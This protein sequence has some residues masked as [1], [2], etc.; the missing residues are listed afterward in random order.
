MSKVK[1]EQALF[2]I[3]L[4]ASLT[5]TRQSFVQK[6]ANQYLDQTVVQH[7]INALLNEL[8]PLVKND[9]SVVRLTTF[10]GGKL[11]KKKNNL[12]VNKQIPPLVI[13][14]RLPNLKINTLFSESISFESEANTKIS[15]F[16]TKSVDEFEGVEFDPD[17]LML[18]G[19][20]TQVGDHQFDLYGST[21]L[22]NGQVQSVVVRIKVT[23]VPDPKSLWKNIPSDETARFHKPDTHHAYCENSSMLLMGCSVRGRSHAHKGI[24]RDDDFKLYCDKSSEWIIS[25]VADGAGS[26]KYSRQGA[27]VAVSNATDSLKESL[28]GH[29]GSALEK[30][31]NDFSNDSNEENQKSLLEVYQHTIVKAVFSAAKAINNCVDASKGD[32]VKDFSTTLILAA[33]KKVQGG[34]LVISFWI[35]DGGIAIYDKNKTVVLMGEPDSGEFAGQTRFLDNRIFEDGSVYRRV[36]VEKVESMSALILATDGITDAWFETEKQ[37]DSLPHWD[38]LWNELEPHIT[39]KNREDGL[40]GLTQWMDFWSKGNHDDRTISVCLV[41]E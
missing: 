19:T 27:F 23:F 2:E 39:N 6:R 13:N 7:H 25:C 28:N 32:S 24:H 26:C 15:F 17:K 33:H 34:Y 31:Y 30:T 4:Q 5:N 38:R 35:G 8:T 12:S 41:K 1:L 37:L 22:A 18:S 21:P 9:K 40:K 20:T 36:R 14:V 29:Y 16:Q 10:E 11:H 3:L